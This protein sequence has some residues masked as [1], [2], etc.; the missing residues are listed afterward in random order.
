MA[1]EEVGNTDGEQFNFD[2]PG[3]ELV[4]TLVDISD[5]IPG[6]YGMFKI[7]VFEV[8]GEDEN[9]KVLLG[10]VLR[11][12]FEKARGNVGDLYKIVYEEKKQSKSNKSR[13]YNDWSIYIDR[14]KPK[15]AVSKK[16][17]AWDS[18]EAF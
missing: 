15:A 8:E 5:E 12:K 1:W 10:K 4:G 17:D 6:D 13:S 2:E 3:K 14:Q 16:S 11:D 18:D 9:Q 7:A